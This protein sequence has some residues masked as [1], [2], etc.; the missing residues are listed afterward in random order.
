[1]PGSGL[2]GQDQH[3]LHIYIVHRKLPIVKLSL[4]CCNIM[5]MSERYRFFS[6]KECEFY[7]CHKLKTEGDLNCLFCYCPLYFI[8]CPGDFSLLG[9]GFKDCSGCLLPH[10]K[11]GWE[12]V[13]KIL[14]KYSEK[15]KDNP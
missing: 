14:Q 5:V 1:M 6:H 11:G 9:N 8:D 4:K 12:R 15:G 2:G 3:F 7:P 13:L 10:E